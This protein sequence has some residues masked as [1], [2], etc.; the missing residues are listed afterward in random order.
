MTQ[1]PPLA[2]IAARARNGVIGLD[3]RMPWHLPE[4]LAYFKR[5]TLGKPVVMGRKTFESIGRPLPGR[6][7]IVVTRNPG[8]QAAGVQVAHS[9][10]AAL[11]LAAV[12]APEEIMLIG[13]AELYRQALP[14]ADV[15]YLTEID[16]EFAGDAFFPEV[17]LARWRIDREEAGQRDSDGLRWRFVRYLPRG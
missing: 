15:L 17:D 10:D 8:W 14:Q 1:H 2:L 7:N 4:D 12:A 6:L 16:A 9:L 5:V 3:N 13:G 11:A